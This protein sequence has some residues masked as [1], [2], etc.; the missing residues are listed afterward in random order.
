METIIAEVRQKEHALGTGLDSV[1]G[2]H[3]SLAEDSAEIEVVLESVRCAPSYPRT[4]PRETQEKAPTERIPDLATSSSLSTEEPTNPQE[5]ARR[6]M[7]KQ[8]QVATR[9]RRKSFRDRFMRPVTQCVSSPPPP[10]SPPRSTKQLG[11]AAR[12]SK[13][14]AS[15]S[16]QD[17]TT[18]PLERGRGRARERSMRGTNSKA[19]IEKERQPNNGSKVSTSSRARSKNSAG[20]GPLQDDDIGPP[21]HLAA[22]FPEAP[23]PA[24]KPFRKPSTIDL[25]SESLISELSSPA[26]IIRQESLGTQS[27]QGVRQALQKMELELAAAGDAGKRV[28][29]EKIMNALNL[30]AHSLHREDQ[31]EALAKELDAWIDESVITGTPG[32]RV[33][34]EDDDY[35]DD[36]PS[37]DETCSDGSS[38]FDLDAFDDAG[39][40]GSSGRN[41]TTEAPFQDLFTRVGKF[42]T[43]SEEDKFVVQQVLSDLLWTETGSNKPAIRPIQEE[44]FEEDS[45]GDLPTFDP[46]TC[47]LE[48]PAREPKATTR[49]HSWWR[50]N[51][52]KSGSSIYNKKGKSYPQNPVES[53]LDPELCL[54]SPTGR[55]NPRVPS[56]KSRKSRLATG[57]MPM[58]PRHPAALKERQRTPRY[59][60]EGSNQADW[61]T[62]A[63]NTSTFNRNS[64]KENSSTVFSSLPNS[65]VNDGSVHSSGVSSFD[66][67]EFWRQPKSDRYT[68]PSE[69]KTSSR[70]VNY[71]SHYKLSQ[72]GRDSDV[73]QASMKVD[74]IDDW[75]F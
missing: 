74:D 21:E 1:S 67:S 23:V 48:E 34:I 56:A 9:N 11:I 42:L 4:S 45:F 37:E 68:I 59:A 3:T 30:M 54:P 64:S 38:T 12:G 36:E 41:L 40:S 32:R 2:D 44:N 24:T 29:R 70:Q 26:A 7:E 35:E 65:T 62:P 57:K 69:P 75:D 72:P 6:F 43:I 31:K 50:K 28:P 52:S 33:P 22:A 5:A 49:G 63:W 25:A 14:S 8:Q 58:P 17:P 13:M 55:V 60:M 16:T 61:N 18:Q 19:V 71:A 51:A 10:P 73:L 20:Y 46:L 47:S 27:I 15:P 53:L 66:D 39:S